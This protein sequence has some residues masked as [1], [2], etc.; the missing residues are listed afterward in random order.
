M[1]DRTEI[2]EQNGG[3]VR[4]GSGRPRASRLLEVAVKTETLIRKTWRPEPGQAR[5]TGDVIRA[6]YRY[7]GD[8]SGSAE[9]LDALVQFIAEQERKR[10]EEEP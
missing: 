4:R 2:E 7:T 10:Q 6:R 5:K 9:R 8:A 1:A 3:E